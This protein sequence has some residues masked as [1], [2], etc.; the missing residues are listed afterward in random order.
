MKNKKSALL[1]LLLCVLMLGH[2]QQFT[3][4]QQK[5]ID[6]FNSVIQTAAHDTAVAKA[7]Y[8]LSEILYLSNIDTLRILCEKSAEISKLNLKKKL[9]DQEVIAFKTILAGSYNNLGYYY[10]SNGDIPKGLEYYYKS[11]EIDEELNDDEGIA[12]TL[13]NI[14]G[15]YKSQG[16]YDKAIEIHHKA[17][18]YAER[19]GNKKYIAL[20]YNNLGYLCHQTNRLDEALTYHT[21]S[22]KLSEEIGNLDRQAYSLNNI[23]ITYKTKGD[24]LLSIQHFNKA[25]AIWKEIGN[26][27]GLTSLMIN[28]GRLYFKFGENKL[29]KNYAQ[30]AFNMAQDAGYAN[31]V[32]T[33]AIFLSDIHQKENDWKTAF[34]M[35][36]LAV[37]MRDSIKNADTEK[38]IIRQRSAYEIEKRDREIEL[39]ATQNELQ[40]VKLDKNRSFAI[41]IS[42]LLG[43]SMI[44]IF[45]VIKNNRRKQVINNLLHK[46]NEAKS[47]IIKEIH[48]RVKNNLHVVNSLLRRQVKNIDDD[49]VV[50]MFKIAQSRVVS[51]AILHEKMYKTSA[52]EAINVKEHLER[53]AQDLVKAYEVDTDIKLKL[54]IEQVELDMETLVPLGL[55][56]NELITN[57]LKYAFKNRDKGII[58]LS[59]QK[60]LSEGIELLI[61]DDGVGIKPLDI[62]HQESMGTQII[63]TFVKQLNGTINLI[64]GS[65]TLYKVAFNQ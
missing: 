4:T 45:F 14:G 56:I 29:A 62:G 42:V 30:D 24:S 13:N 11:L 3:P 59:L 22:L 26:I 55:I 2:A 28:K 21:K 50:E 5:H 18:S 63:N 25:E 64:E 54:D 39:L 17:L 33:S 10:K 9:N 34:E 1:G 23:G 8:N 7:Y 32:K 53:L 44:L 41:L 65:G 6:S 20:M 12:V 58:Y 43:L 16:D 38:A 40:E 19:T 57:S 37:K 49:E 47:T 27:K 48:H 61:G 51:M 15:V 36:E 52:H 60:N 31:L 35:N 46:Q